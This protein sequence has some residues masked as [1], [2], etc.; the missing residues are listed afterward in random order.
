[1]AENIVMNLQLWN[2]SSGDVPLPRIYGINYGVYL[3]NDHWYPYTIPN[4]DDFKEGLKSVCKQSVMN[5]SVTVLMP[6]TA[7]RTEANFFIKAY[8]DKTK[9]N[10]FVRIACAYSSTNDKSPIKVANPDT[11]DFAGINMDDFKITQYRVLG[12]NKKFKIPGMFEVF[13]FESKTMKDW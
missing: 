13:S 10:N 11:T 5:D 8:K 4:L 9:V 2:L 6:I 12:E 1:M 7:T 3:V